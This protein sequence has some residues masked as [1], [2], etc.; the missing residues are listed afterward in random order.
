[1]QVLVADDDPT[2]RLILTAHLEAA[3]HR[4]E[5]V[6]DGSAVIAAFQAAAP[7]ALVIDAMMP[8]GGWE[9]IETLRKDPRFSTVP[10]VLLSARDLPD[11]MRRGYAAGASLVM[12]KDQDLS[13]LGGLL[14]EMQRRI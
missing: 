2:V 5:T 10:M 12:S 11:D 1:M 9:V 8:V 7:D 6:D 14:E 3:G 4:V 13:T